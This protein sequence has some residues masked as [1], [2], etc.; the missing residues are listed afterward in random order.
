[1]PVEAPEPLPPAE[2]APR[3]RGRAAHRRPRRRHAR[4]RPRR[5]RRAA[6]AAPAA[7]PRAPPP[8]PG[9]RRTAAP[10]PR[11]AGEAER[12]LR[13]LQ[14]DARRAELIRTLQALTAAGAAGAGAAVDR[15][16]PPRLPRPAAAA[17]APRRARRARRA[18][19]GA[20][21]ILAPNTLGAQLLQ[22]ASQRLSALSE[23]LVGAVQTIADLP[24]MISPGCPPWRATRSRSSG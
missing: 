1:M 18:A 12:L 15:A 22:G 20:G 19:A 10:A 2:T 11:P 5:A 16:A 9:R 13:L 14:D 3:Q 8:R 17:P 6:A 24:A 23:Q 21:D 7:R 4:R